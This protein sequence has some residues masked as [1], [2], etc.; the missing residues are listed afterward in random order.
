M[1]TRVTNALDRALEAVPNPVAAVI[2]VALFLF[3]VQLLGAATQSAAPVISELFH[4][5]V[6]GDASALGLGWLGAYV[7]ANGSVVA[8]L[9]VSLFTAEIVSPTQLFLL[10]AG[11]RLGAVAVVVFI[12]ALDWLQK[13]RYTLRKS[14]RMGLLTFTLTHSIYLPV[15]VIGYLTLPVL[16]K[17]LLTVSHGWGTIGFQS[18]AVFGPVMAA[19]TW[20]LGPTIGV[21]AGMS[22]LVAS[23]NLFDRVLAQV[24][25]NVLR[26][27]VFD[28]LS[29]PAPAFVIGLL[30]TGV[31]TSIAFSLGVIV[32]LYNRGYIE[33]DELIPYVLGA[34]I[35]TLV[36]T[37]LVAVVLG[38]TGGI[39]IVLHLLVIA[40][41]V[42]AIALVAL[43]VYTRAIVAFDQRLV[44][45]RRA[46][47]VFMTSLVVVPLLFFIGPIL[48]G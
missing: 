12:G 19:I 25:I 26:T 23:L 39:A 27:T 32:P 14:I 6:V 13:K 5:F 31:T 28:R 18:L 35:G 40:A 34:N 17:P 43:P 38:S 3:A 7:V 29:N 46:F 37:L 4:R 36:D 48:I 24:D 47:L 44:D 16:Q 1:S 41:L 30:I 21:L 11:S 8:A 33:R 15:T 22:L 9:A 45:D 2:A 10:L 20:F 42:T